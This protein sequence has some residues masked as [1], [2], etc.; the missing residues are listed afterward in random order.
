MFISIQP[1]NPQA[2]YYP[3]DQ[4]SATITLHGPLKD[5]NIIVY[6]RLGGLY[7]SRVTRRDDDYYYQRW[8]CNEE[9][10]VFQGPI[11]L[12]DTQETSWNVELFLPLN[13]DG[14][15]NS[16]KS[17]KWPWTEQ[18]HPLPASIEAQQPGGGDKMQ[19]EYSLR[20]KAK[21]SSFF[22]M[23]KKAYRTIFVRQ[24]PVKP[25][26]LTAQPVFAE[27]SKQL[28]IRMNPRSLQQLFSK[29]KAESPPNVGV[30]VRATIPKCLELNRPASLWLD[31]V[32]EEGIGPEWSYPEV[33]FLSVEH[34]IKAKTW[35]RQPD[36]ARYWLV[37]KDERI[38]SY[39]RNSRMTE[40]KALYFGGVLDVRL[41]GSD[42]M[43]GFR[44][45][46]VSR[47]YESKTTVVMEIEGK[48][49]IL[50]FEVENLL[51]MPPS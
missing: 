2:V 40:G 21:R 28:V 44:S 37:V 20:A 49:H 4:V 51:V 1:R 34:R 9:L 7:T 45:Y 43:T 10:I 11:C 30:T 31:F 5:K 22:R 39:K 8:L 36:G 24:Q 25:S 19:I 16:L 17:Y 33:R 47:T 14:I 12:L 35:A 13:A 26:D 23:S 48:K 42:M 6:A 27:R 38:R 3:G 15:S 29:R 46:F 50:V 32:Y 18:E 41:E